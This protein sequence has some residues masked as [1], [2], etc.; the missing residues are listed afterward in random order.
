MPTSRTSFKSPFLFAIVI[1]TILIYTCQQFYY[2]VSS[3]PQQPQQ[4][5]TMAH[6]D[7]DILSDL[8]VSLRQAS[9]SSAP[10]AI[11]VKVT[12]NSPKPVTILTWE[13]PLD[14]L[15]LQLGLLSITPAGASTPLDIPTIKV[16]RKLPPGEDSLVSLAPGESH[17]NEIVLKELLVPLAQLRGKKSSVTI[18]GRWGRVWLAPRDQLTQQAI[19]A[20]GATEGGAAAVSGAFETGP[21]EIDVQ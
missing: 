15:A 21:V 8:A 13:S 16:S 10:P 1:I 7:S 6:H 3:L 14:P 19:E 12:N 2:D 5:A 17:E 18:Q 20:L 9:S 4:E 11:T